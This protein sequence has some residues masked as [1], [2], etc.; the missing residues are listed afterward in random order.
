MEKEF[1]K[2]GDRSHLPTREMLNRSSRTSSQSQLGAVTANQGMIEKLEIKPEDR[3]SSALMIIE[4]LNKGQ[5]NWGGAKAGSG[6]SKM[7]SMSS[8]RP[9]FTSKDIEIPSRRGAASQLAISSFQENIQATLKCTDSLYGDDDILS[10]IRKIV[11]KKKARGWGYSR[12]SPKKSP[13]SKPVPSVLASSRA[14][15][16]RFGSEFS[17]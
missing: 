11:Q 13:F 9:L 12:A 5:R 3:S 8:L 15:S 6:Q 7:D 17:R 2:D 1:Q 4:H 14:Q 16:P 10:E